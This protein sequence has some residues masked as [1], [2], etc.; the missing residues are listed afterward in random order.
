MSGLW[1]A[2]LGIAVALWIA[3]TTRTGRRLLG[4]FR[5]SRGSGRAPREDRDYLL[6]VCQGDPARVARLLEEARRGRGEVSEAEAYRLAIR[7][8]LRDRT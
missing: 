2:A 1:I 6:R 5:P 7:R 4:R 3:S 8:H